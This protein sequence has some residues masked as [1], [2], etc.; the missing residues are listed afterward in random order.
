MFGNF[1]ATLKYLPLTLALAV[2]SRPLSA[3][4]AMFVDSVGNVGIGTNSPSSA[5]DISREAA[6]IRTVDQSGIEAQRDLML[7][8]NNGATTF[9]FQNRALPQTWE[10]KINNSGIFTIKDT[11]DSVAEFFLFQNGDARFDGEVDARAFNTISSATKKERIMPVDGGVILAKLEEL[12]ITEWSYRNEPEDRHV[13]P[14]A[15][16]FYAIF[17]LGPDNRHINSTDLAGL[18]LAAAKA[19]DM[20]NDILRRENSELRERVNRLERHVGLD[21]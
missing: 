16:D 14:M 12:P 8:S 4:D 11:S 5:L 2:L 17:G 7:L 15:E 1:S 13:G 20:E 3:Q 18:A 21:Q 10:F 19:L 9:N 6:A